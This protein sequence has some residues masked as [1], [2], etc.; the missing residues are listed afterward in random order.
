M[1]ITYNRG[2]VR[3]IA[4]R[5]RGRSAQ[6]LD[7]GGPR[8]DP[9]GGGDGRLFLQIRPALPDP[10]AAFAQRSHTTLSG[11]DFVQKEDSKDE[12]INLQAVGEGKV[13]LSRTPQEKDRLPDRI[14]LDRRGL[15]SIPHIVGEPGLRLLSLQHNL[16]NSLSGLSPLDL[17]KLVFLDVYDNQIDKITSLERLFGLRVLLMGKNRIKRIEGLNNLIKLEVLDLHGNRI[18]KVCGLSNLSELK[19]LNLAG[20]QIKCVGQTDLQGLVSLRELNF[21]RNRLRKLL[22]FQNTPKLQKLYLG[23]NDLQSVEDMSSLSEAVSLIDVSLDGNPVALGGDCVPFLV[24]YLPNLLTLS[25][26]HVTEQVRRAAMAWRNNKEAAHAAYC[27]L[28]GAAQ[29]E[30]RRDQIIN[31]ARTNWELLR[32][33][34]KCFIPST[35]PTKNV[36]IDKEF[37]IDATAVITPP[38]GIE[39]SAE[40]AALPDV[41]VSLQQAETEDS[42]CKNTS[43]DA[44][45]KASTDIAPKASPMRKLQ[46][47]STARKPSERRVNFSDR[48]ASQ[49]TD[50]SHSTSTSSDLRLPPIL[51]PIIS[52]LENVKLADSSEPILKRWESISSV[53]P[54]VDSSF[55]SLPTS[56]SD[57]EEETK[58]RPIR[59]M[60][61]AL[62]R[63]ENF[64]TMRSKSVCDPESRRS[65]SKNSDISE[66]ASNISSSTNVGSVA[67]SS[68]SGSDHNS[69]VLRREGS[70]NSRTSRNIRSATI[71][72]RNERASSANRASTARTKSVKNLNLAN[73]KSS[74]PVPKSLPASKDREQ[75]VDYLV[76]VCDGVVSAW[77]AGAVRRLARDWDWERARTVTRAAYHYVHYNAVAQSLPELKSKFPNVSHI[78]VRAT[79]LQWLGQLH[80]LAELRGVTG[81][82]VLPEGNPIYAKIWRE[83]AI[84]RLAHWGLKEINDEPVTDEEIKTANRTYAGLSDIV[85]RAIPD[86]PLQPLLSRLG[87]SGNS[88]VSAKA[89]LRAA[90]PALRDVIAK[91]ALQYK[92]GNVS[93]EDMSWRVRGRG[94]LSHAIDLACGAA[95]RLKALEVQWPT[96]LVEM[97]EDILRDFADMETHVKEQMKMLMDTM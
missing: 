68:T 56:S 62:R 7:A 39:T 86:A 80:A 30:A 49:D 35:S 90:D 3:K 55:S 42:D 16:I 89:W 73:F 14:S 48:S 96:I 70:L 91:E 15:S 28:G 44:N 19:V 6:S 17:G 2:N 75:G 97:I 84:Y 36:D 61:T 69:K 47:S 58:K 50:A 45:A 81:L 65:K 26:M 9:G 22:G 78:S 88:A 51:L 87:R 10:R 72:R 37:S 34:N 53:E 59:R 21:K 41:V 40:A 93:Q 31:N 18:G 11:N 60:A 63:R 95:Q 29:Q 38:G 83:Y 52:S 23:N 71:S 43:S 5:T 79:G 54:V 20:N 12:A 76:E 85:L 25:N 46:R 57:S 1:P 94:Q 77:G 74:E 24:S 33:E 67:N 13:Q 32:S 8:V 4:F 64:S 27:A 82:T 66:N 92:K